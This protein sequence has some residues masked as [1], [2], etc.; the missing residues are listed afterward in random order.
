MPCSEVSFAPG[1]PATDD[2]RN[3]TEGPYWQRNGQL[4]CK[5]HRQSP[6][7][8]PGG[9]DRESSWIIPM[10]DAKLDKID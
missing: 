2:R 7:K 10:V 9:V 3:E 8:R 6:S 4:A 1:R 5:V